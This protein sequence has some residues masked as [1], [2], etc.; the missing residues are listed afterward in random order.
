MLAG[1]VIA[2]DQVWAALPNEAIGSAEDVFVGARQ[3]LGGKD[4][5]SFFIEYQIFK[6]MLL[7]AEFGAVESKAGAAWRRRF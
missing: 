7:D 2:R 5:T 6:E 4:S 1:T 3:P